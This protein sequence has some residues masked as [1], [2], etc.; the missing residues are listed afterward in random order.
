MFNIV[1]C[2]DNPKFLAALQFLLE[3]ECKRIVPKGEDY[4]IGPEFEEGRQLLAYMK[5]H[6]VD[7]LFLDIDMP[8]MNGFELAKVLCR[9][10]KQTKIVF[11]SAYDNFVYNAFE[12]YPFAYIRKE[13]LTE[14]LPAVIKRIVE[15][16]RESD[17]QLHL[18][19]SEG[20]KA[21]NAGDILYVESK[22]NYCDVYLV[23]DKVYTV[24]SALSEFEE[25]LDK[26]DFFRI[27]SAYVINLEYVDRVPE[28]GYVTVNGKSLPIAQRRIRDFK[29]AYA[30]YI[31]RCFGT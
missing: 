10:Y 30:D 29:T 25:L 22:K 5:D 28:N 23:Q 26:S 15:K 12:Y 27:H 14:E 11:M 6:H 18:T 8:Q 9:E 1:S 21:V 16:L 24:R 17:K 7:V 13:R 2:D 31:R 19:T 20:V 4:H 3:K